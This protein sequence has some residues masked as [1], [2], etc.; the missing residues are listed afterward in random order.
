MGLA[1]AAGDLPSVFLRGK[2]FVLGS[3]IEWGMG[4]GDQE[5]GVKND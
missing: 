2:G 1:G 4:G 5:E 3:L